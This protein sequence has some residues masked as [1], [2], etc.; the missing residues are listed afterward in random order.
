MF[1]VFLRL[2]SIMSQLVAVVKLLSLETGL[3][4]L[5]FPVE[6]S[7]IIVYQGWGCRGLSCFR[8]M[9]LAA[10]IDPSEGTAPA[11]QYCRLYLC[12]WSCTLWLL[13]PTWV[14][15]IGEHG[16]SLSP[17]LFG[18]HPI[19]CV[20]LGI[21]NNVDA[22]SCSLGIAQPPELLTGHYRCPRER[23]SVPESQARTVLHLSW[24]QH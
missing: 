6:V 10:W 23:L 19:W 12:H 14:F 11:R 16:K 15:S 20:L 1:V 21:W 22:T 9:T 4:R 7:Y 18:H 3:M 24:K 8:T 17:D 5:V 2:D 13:E